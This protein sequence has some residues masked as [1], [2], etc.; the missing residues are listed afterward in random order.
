MFRVYLKS[1]MH[2]REL[3]YS[4]QIVRSRVN[5]TLKY[6]RLTARN[7]PPQINVDPS[8]FDHWIRTLVLLTKWNGS[9]VPRHLPAGNKQH[10]SYDCILTSLENFKCVE[11]N[12][13]PLSECTTRGTPNLW[14]TSVSRNVTTLDLHEFR[15]AFKITNF[16]K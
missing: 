7:I 6:V 13:L 16:V 9:H 5:I 11:I 3:P 12:C 15:I 10:S 1:C 4:Y 2:K 14:N 8:L